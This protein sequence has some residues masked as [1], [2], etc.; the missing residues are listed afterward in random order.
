MVQETTKQAAYRRRQMHE[1]AEIG[2]LPEVVNKDR[3]DACKNNLLLFCTT[4]FKDLFYLEFGDVHLQLIKD[5]QDTILKGDLKAVALP[6]SSGKTTLCQVG[7]LWALLYGHRRFA[8]LVASDTSRAVQ[9]LQDI[10][11][12][13]DTNELVLEDFPESAFPFKALENVPQ[14]A[15]TQTLNGERTRIEISAGKV[16]FPFIPGS[17]S[18]CARMYATGLTSSSLRGLGA[19]T[20]D[21]KKIRPDLVLVDDPSTAES[22]R[23]YEQNNTRERLL[24]AD[25]LGMAGAGK[26]IACLITCTVIAEDDLATRL[27][28]RKRNPE[29]RGTRVQLMPTLPDNLDLWREYNLRRIEDPEDA[30]RFYKENRAALDKGASVTWEARYNSDEI[31]AIQNGMNLYFRDEKA[32]LSEYQNQAAA[33]L[34]DS[35]RYTPAAVS[36]ARTG[37][38]FF[39]E[40]S[41]IDFRTAF[42]DCHNDLLYYAI[43]GWSKDFIG[44]VLAFGSYPEQSAKIYRKID[45]HPR[46]VDTDTGYQSGVIEAV[47]HVLSFADIRAVGVDIGYEQSL[48]KDAIFASPSRRRVVGVKG[49]AYGARSNRQI[50]DYKPSSTRKIGNHWMLDIDRGRRVMLQDVTYWKTRLYKSI[51]ERLIMINGDDSDIQQLYNHLQA[52][53]ASL[54]TANNKSV[55]EWTAR[56]GDN[57]LLDCLT[58]CMS[59]A[60]FCGAKFPNESDA[61]KKRNLYKM[62]RDSNE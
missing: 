2:P 45:A 46:L 58:G 60:S 62:I 26:K 30:T 14:R 35:L 15:R 8:V 7:I 50:A 43:C 28:D 54:V 10:R 33:D 48:T 51:T 12:W 47:E 34:E 21:G 31:S 18:S 32:F 4:Y 27:L 49:A 29:F 56:P 6:R 25:V 53:R 5:I 17:C 13:L 20:A 19:T 41:F 44:Q 3:R 1:K 52:E 38:D 55:Y 39:Y 40:E 23:S 36:L 9:L 22:A 16:S 24:K 37:Q 42:I 59:L 57:H 11:L 61:P